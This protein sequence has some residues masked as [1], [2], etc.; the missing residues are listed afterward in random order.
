[1]YD[2]YIMRSLKLH[3]RVLHI[4]FLLIFLATHSVTAGENMRFR[5]QTGSEVIY[6]QSTENSLGQQLKLSSESETGETHEVI[7]DAQTLESLQWAHRNAVDDTDYTARISGRTI[8]VTGK[9]QG[10]QVDES[11]Q[12]EDADPWIQS[13]ERSLEPF[14]RSSRD[15]M[16]FWTVQ[17]GDLTLRKLQAVRRGRSTIDVDGERVDAWEVRISL[18]GISSMF[19]SAT[20][21]YRVSDGQFVR[22]E[23]VR[24]WPGT[25]RTV[26]ELVADG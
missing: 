6:L 22:Y 10:R 9:N 7:V 1:M 24:G 8:R 12:L 5:E 26:V 3:L 18:P 11:F 15:R 16:Q 20:Y 14:V 23:G 25:P 19:W 21:W 4:A 17:P 2:I 13:I